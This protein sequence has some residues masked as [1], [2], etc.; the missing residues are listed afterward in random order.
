MA[1]IIPAILPKTY[2]ELEEKLSFLR[3]LIRMVQVDITD[4]KFVPSQTWPYTNERDSRFRSL[5]AEKEGLP[6]WEDFDFE[7][8]LMV[9]DPLLEADRW[10]TAGAS[11]IIIHVESAPNK[12]ESIIDSVKARGCEIGLALNTETPNETIYPFIEKADFVQFMGIA[13]I[14]FQGEPFDERV[15]A[16]LRETREKFPNIIM[17]VDGGVSLETAPRLIEAGANRLVAG[18]AIFERPNILETIEQFRNLT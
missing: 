4:G 17:S 18:S 3:G 14:G 7:F 13:R 12:L 5:L 10:I 6:Y 9:A 8:D 1:D 2:A 15:L 16:K 11:R